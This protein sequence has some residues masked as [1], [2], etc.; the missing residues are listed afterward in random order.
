MKT[1][2]F[3]CLCLILEM[4]LRSSASGFERTHCRRLLLWGSRLRS[5]VSLGEPVRSP[6][7]LRESKLRSLA[8]FGDLPKLGRLTDVKKGTWVPLGGIRRSWFPCGKRIDAAAFS[9]KCIEVVHV[10]SSWH[11]I[12]A[13]VLLHEAS[14]HRR[15]EIERE[16]F[17]GGLP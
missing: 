12:D 3:T 7:L 17:P 4:K 6:R 5:L 2:T 15:A 14:Q 8:S 13:A 9:W 1:L 10:G 11:G 16:H